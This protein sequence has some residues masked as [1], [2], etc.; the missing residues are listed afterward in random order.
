MNMIII[1]S[2]NLRS[3]KRTMKS[4]KLPVICFCHFRASFLEARLPEL[5]SNG[6]SLQKRSVEHLFDCYTSS[7][8]DHE[9]VTKSV[10]HAPRITKIEVCPFEKRNGSVERTKEKNMF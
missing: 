1:C 4:V 9:N 2:D 5:C 8:S 10:D 7:F 3:V 6:I